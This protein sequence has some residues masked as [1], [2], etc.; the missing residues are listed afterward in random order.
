MKISDY[1]LIVQQ[2]GGAWSE[3]CDI[4]DLI[5][6]SSICLGRHYSVHI[7]EHYI[8][9]LWPV[10]PT[11]GL[12]IEQ[13]AISRLP[14]TSG[15]MPEFMIRSY[16]PIT[17]CDV[18]LKVSS[19]FSEALAKGDDDITSVIRMLNEY[20]SVGDKRISFRTIQGNRVCA[21]DKLSNVLY[22]GKKLQVYIG[23]ENILSWWRST[24]PDYENIHVESVYDLCVGIITTR[25]LETIA[26]VSAI[27][28]ANL[29]SVISQL[30]KEL[31]KIKQGAYL[32]NKLEK[33]IT[34][35]KL[36]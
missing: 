28:I 23:E 13:M 22:D 21:T 1:G 19:S 36:K 30:E 5:Q 12:A 4:N 20:L 17:I 26:D 16:E 31:T 8:V 33:I 34:N 29:K 11:D 10:E 9:T 14:V 32:V 24:V 3:Y 6:T 27:L 35:R 7:N 18:L 25:Q 15:I 2:H